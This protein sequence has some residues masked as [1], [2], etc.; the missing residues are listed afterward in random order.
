VVVGVNQQQASKLAGIDIPYSGL[1]FKDGAWVYPHTWCLKLLAHENIT[2]LE[3]TQAEKIVRLDTTIADNNNWLVHTNVSDGTSSTGVSSQVLI[4]CNANGAKLLDH[5]SF[6]PTKP[7]AGQVTQLT[8]QAINLNTVLCGDHYVAP[9]HNGQLNFGASYRIK[10]DNTEI[11]AS[12]NETNIENLKSAFPSIGD[13]LDLS[14]NPTGR[15]SVRCTSPDYTPIAGPICDE[16]FFMNDFSE[17]K[18]NRKWKFKQQAKFVSGLYIN[19][20]HGSRGL[21][22][23]PLCAELITAYITGEPLPMPKAQ[24]DMLNPNRFLVNNIIKSK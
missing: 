12:Y 10:S 20:A 3:N 5:L 13:Q 22:S 17:L 11:L 2:V 24:A 9:S 19:I 8:P 6:L 7:V 21:T 23:A 16:L 1:F 15:A 4:V 14:V 18:K